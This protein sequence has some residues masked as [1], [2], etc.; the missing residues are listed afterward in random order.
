VKENKHVNR[1]VKN[2]AVEPT[3]GAPTEGAQNSQAFGSLPPA[4]PASPGKRIDV[5]MEFSA[6]T[7]EVIVLPTNGPTDAGRPFTAGASER[8]VRAPD[9]TT[10][11]RANLLAPGTKTAA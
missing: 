6:F 11:T 10:K 3:A 8:V 7:K 9:P 4:L 5:L 2:S 1:R